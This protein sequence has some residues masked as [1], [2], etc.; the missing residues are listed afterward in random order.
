MH[1]ICK[2]PDSIPGHHN[3]EN[4]PFNVFG[5]KEK[6]VACM[7]VVKEQ[8]IVV[9]GFNFIVIEFVKFLYIIGQLLES[10]DLSFA[11]NVKCYNIGI[12]R[13]SNAIKPILYI[14]V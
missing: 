9:V 7:F 11:A 5:D 4:V 6:I 1:N 13:H 8:K 10:R 2:V 14:N 3:K 12:R